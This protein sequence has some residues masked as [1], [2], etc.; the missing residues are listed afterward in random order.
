M[1]KI[2]VLGILAVVL[3][4]FVGMGRSMYA[5]GLLFDP[6]KPSNQPVFQDND[7]PLLLPAGSPQPVLEVKEE[8]F[9]FGKMERGEHRKHGFVFTNTGDAPL[10]LK[11]GQPSCKCT[12]SEIEKKV[13]APGESTTVVLEWH[14]EDTSGAF[15]TS[16]PITTNDR[17]R[18]RVE[19]VIKGTVTQSFQAV[20]TSVILGKFA[21]DEEK[22]GKLRL[23]AFG[24]KP[25]DV[26]SHEFTQPETAE[27]FEVSSERLESDQV[28]WQDATQGTVVTVAAKPGLPPGSIRQ[29]LRLGTSLS[30]V[31]PIDIPIQGTVKSHITVAG[32][33]RWNSRNQS[34]SLGTI[35]S[36]EGE[37]Y[38]LRVQ[39]S[40]EHR[41][42]TEL[43]IEE[44][45]SPALQVELGEKEELL[46]G[47][48]VQYPLKIEVPAGSRPV[49]HLGSSF[50]ENARIV[51]STTHPGIQQMVIRVRFAVEG[52]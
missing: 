51:L 18:P 13:I 45:T 32:D 27:F 38:L 14:T 1:K 11:A 41:A 42:S 49:N 24:D 52:S 30:H 3:G 26:V 7:A 4:I 50:G 47:R 34:L 29:T 21:V 12:V 43:N 48:I 31:P 40:G 35:K 44:V 33:R 8:I 10:A 5:V 23:Y 16:A 37:S 17:K 2:F 28:T 15:R 6:D 9:D 20:P 46:D 25:I 36:S 19:L 39:V 22:S